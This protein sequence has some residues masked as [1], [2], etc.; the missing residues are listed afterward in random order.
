MENKY[1]DIK[2]TLYELTDKY[3][4]AIDLLVSVGFDNMKDEKQR[5]T[6]GKSITL[7]MALSMKKVNVETFTK[8]LVDIIESN[9]DQ[10]S[11]LL[12]DKKEK[13]MLM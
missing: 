6:I 5:S 11:E 10:L 13:K 12:D 3:E 1:F 7:D 2:D 4:E 9:K 8:Q